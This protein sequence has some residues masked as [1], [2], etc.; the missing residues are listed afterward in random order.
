MPDLKVLIREW[1]E[2]ALLDTQ[3]FLVDIK[4][5]RRQSLTISVT[6]DGFQRVGIQD[7]VTISKTIKAHLN[8]VET[9]D[10]NLTISS[11]GV[12]QPLKIFKQY[13]KNMNRLFRIVCRSGQVVAG[14]LIALN[15]TELSLEV[16]SKSKQKPKSIENIAFKNIKQA[17]VTPKINFSS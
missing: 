3:L 7:C 8:T 16:D 6:I 5:I 15:E 2:A 13:Q 4:I 1:V 10:Y 14:K 17:I 11:A 12:G 9:E